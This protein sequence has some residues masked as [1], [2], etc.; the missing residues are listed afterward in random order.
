MLSYRICLS[1][2]CYTGYKP[3]LEKNNIYLNHAV[4]NANSVNSRQAAGLR[5][6]QVT[7]FLVDR[8]QWTV[9]MLDLESKLQLIFPQCI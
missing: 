7:M 9:D 5:E 3:G 1:Q 2:T 6:L 8:R 4:A